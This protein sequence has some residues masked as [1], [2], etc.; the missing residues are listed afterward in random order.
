MLGPAAAQAPR[1]APSSKSTTEG[2]VRLSKASYARLSASTDDIGAALA[3]GL[4]ILR[5]AP[6]S[7][8]RALLAS[9]TVQPAETQVDDAS[10]LQ[11]DQETLE[12]KCS[13]VA[14][15]R[16]VV[17]GVQ[18]FLEEDNEEEPMAPVAVD[19]EAVAA[20]LRGEPA[21]PPDAEVMGVLRGL[22]DAAGAPAAVV[23]VEGPDSDDEV[24]EDDQYAAQLE[25]ELATTEMA[26]SFDRPENDDAPVDVD[27]NLVKNL[28]ESVEAQDGAA[29]GAAA[30]LL[31][32]LGLELPA[33][34]D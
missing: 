22:R 9:D 3:A 13:A 4:E 18:D 8:E 21:P 2:I 25:A 24:D 29:P 30:L 11:V 14:T 6:S 5:K 16:D 19:G 17:S 1:R 23:Q 32:E 26:Q 15:P 27:F 10:W 7:T 33:D 12:R 31:N 20:L 28:L 34:D